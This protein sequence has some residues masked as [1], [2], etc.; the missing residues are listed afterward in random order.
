[1]VWWA[2]FLHPAITSSDR[3]S[4]FLRASNLHHLA[5][6]RRGPRNNPRKPRALSG[7][8]WK[9]GL[10]MKATNRCGSRNLPP[11]TWGLLGGPLRFSTACLSHQAGPPCTSNTHTL[12]QVFLSPPVPDKQILLEKK[13]VEIIL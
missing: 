3:L 13:I 5:T 6:A 2:L 11:S 4:L 9:T 7:K 12:R 1:M 8:F 10:R